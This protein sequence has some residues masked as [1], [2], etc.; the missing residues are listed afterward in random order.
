MWHRSAVT[1]QSPCSG[2]SVAMLCNA[3][4]VLMDLQAKFSKRIH[5]MI[6]LYEQEE[7]I[8]MFSIHFKFK[9]HGYENAGNLAS[10]YFCSATM[11]TTLCG[12]LLPRGTTH[13]HCCTH[14]WTRKQGKWDLFQPRM[15]RVGSMLK[16]LKMTYFRKKGV[17]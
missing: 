16:S 6:L 7:N 14:A 13:I 10:W 8:T 2:C 12:W 4:P 1:H 11:L 17:V 5:S 9:A 15:R 3:I